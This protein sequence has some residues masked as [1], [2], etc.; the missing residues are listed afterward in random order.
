MIHRRY[1]CLFGTIALISFLISCAPSVDFISMN[2]KR[3]PKSSGSQLYVFTEHDSL[4]QGAEI[5]GKIS[6]KDAGLTVHCD[7]DVVLARA[8]DKAREAGA[9]AIKLIKVSTPDR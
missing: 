7:Y 1:P 3:E 6:V 9:D 4:P 5:L 8:E 2:A